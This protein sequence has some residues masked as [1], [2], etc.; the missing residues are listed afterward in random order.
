MADSHQ[1]ASDYTYNFVDIVGQL[2]L[3]NSIH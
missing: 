3:P 2:W 1:H